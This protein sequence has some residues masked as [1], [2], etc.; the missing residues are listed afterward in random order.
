MEAAVVHR[1]GGAVLV[2]VQGPHLG[3]QFHPET[4]ADVLSVWKE[5]LSATTSGQQ[6]VERLDLEATTAALDSAR[7]LRREL[8]QELVDRFLDDSFSGVYSTR[9]SAPAS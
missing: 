4:D 9:T 5:R 7:E 1:A 2:F 3:V 8:C 6:A